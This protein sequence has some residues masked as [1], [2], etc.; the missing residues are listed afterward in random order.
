MIS[1]NSGAEAFLHIFSSLK[2]DLSSYPFPSLNILKLASFHGKT[3]EITS[4]PSRLS[5]LRTFLANT[6]LAI[7]IDKL[8]ND[9]CQDCYL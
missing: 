3:I 9:V 8:D 5:S 4:A 6:L 2:S 1:F 7:Q